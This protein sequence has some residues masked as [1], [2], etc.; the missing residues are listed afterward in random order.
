MDP[1][2]IAP[3][4]EPAG[5]AL[6]AE[7]PPYDAS[8]SLALGTALRASGLDADLVAAALT[9]SRLRAKARAKFGDLA[10]DMLFTPEGLEQA[11]RLPVAAR[12]AHRFRTAGATY[13]ADLGCGIGADAMALAGMELR[14]LAV[15]RDPATA[16]VAGIN[17]RALP[18]ARVWQGDAFD[19]DLTG[20]DAVWA[21]PARR[22]TSGARLHRLADYSPAVERLLALRTTGPHPVGMLGLK[23]SPALAH[24]DIPVDARAEWVSVG[25]DVVE[26]GLWFGDLA[27]EGPGRTAL[28]LAVDGV[29]VL[30]ERGDPSAPVTPA[31][32][33]PLGAYLYEPDG[34]VLRAGVVHRVA[35]ETGTHLIDA[36]IAF[37][38][39]DHLRPTPWSTAFRVLDAMP[40]SL[41]RLR[42]YLRERDV[43]TLEIKKRG[44]AL[45]PARL[46]GQ[47]SLRGRASAT[48]VLTRVAGEQRVLVVERVG[49][50]PEPLE[51]PDIRPDDERGDA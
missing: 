7:L 43:G 40:F 51:R 44:S 34:S 33:G 30:A 6:L 13:V 18:E 49:D 15:E 5:W 36:S 32:T 37:L 19:A 41:K 35:E 45:D 25:G 42:A 11:T 16:L 21:D 46:R 27:P 12:H 3:L 23:L 4:L 26:T 14:V 22:T 2:S 47:L 28:L 8:S 24:R 38:T 39:G 29:H 17:L 9:Q 50:R 10:R 1:A 48:I 31:P 20:V